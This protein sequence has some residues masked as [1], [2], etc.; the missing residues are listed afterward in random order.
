MNK[1]GLSGR[2][3][4][5]LGIGLIVI[6][7]ISM[8]FYFSLAGPDYSS[9]YDEKTVSGEISNP[10]KGK[11]VETAVEEFSEYYIY[12]LLVLGKAYN[13]HN[14]PLSNDLPKIEIVVEDAIYNAVIEDGEIIIEEGGLKKKDIVIETTKEELV[15]IL[16]DKDYVQESFGSGE[17]SIKLVAEKSVL[18]AKGYLKLYTELTGKSITGNVARIYLE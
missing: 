14:P 17:S 4:L 16:M 13:L 7:V 10:V 1:R 8:F 11:S 15:K 9:V 6:L 5:F 2:F 12:Y 3:Y 18:F